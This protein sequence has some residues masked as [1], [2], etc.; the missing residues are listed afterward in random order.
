MGT[1]KVICTNEDLGGV[2]LEVQ[3]DKWTAFPAGR[4]ATVKVWY[5][6]AS[7]G[8]NI[9]RLVDKQD[10]LFINSIFSHHFNYA[11]LIKSRAKRKI[12][13]PRGMLDPGSLSQKPWKKQIYLAY[14]KLKGIDRVCEWHATTEQEKHNIQKVFGRKSKVWVVPNFPRVIDFQP[15]D[16]KVGTLAM[17]TIALVSPMKNHLMIL[18]A[19]Q[20]VRSKVSWHIY[21]PIK[22]EEYWK[23]CLKIIVQLPENIEVLYQG[24]V[25]PIH[26]PNA[27]LNGQVAIL[28]SKSE[29]FG[30]SIYEAFI[31]GKPVIT[32]R[33]T[34]WNEL[35][36]KKAGLNV[37]IA[38]E[39]QL[40]EA[41]E[42][43]AD[44]DNDEFTEWS[45]SAR[46]LA[47]SAVDIES[48]KRGYLEMFEG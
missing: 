32:S 46:A 36:G 18:Q 12:I 11:S 14:L 37:G 38:N 39:D 24:D 33:N 40:A 27:L 47:L 31:A 2:K 42:S 28:P 48:I 9:E 17:V 20:K 13:S 8:R 41:I 15:A 34:P 26:V 43:F 30:H 6:S 25:P 10:V 21:G 5:A 4:D 16:K 35:R 1:L 23:A 3:E 22:D 29:N 7:G 45:K 44:M 19:L